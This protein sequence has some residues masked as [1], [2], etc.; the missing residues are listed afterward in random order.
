MPTL[1]NTKGKKV[2]GRAVIETL[3]QKTVRKRELAHTQPINFSLDKG[4]SFDICWQMNE[5]WD[6][7]IK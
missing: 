5:K 3:Y 7:Y 2:E 6:R 4:G 1:I